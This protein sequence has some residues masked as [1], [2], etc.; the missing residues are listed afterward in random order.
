[1][2]IDSIAQHLTKTQNGQQVYFYFSTLDLKYAYSQL[3]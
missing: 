2:L 1:M 3:Q